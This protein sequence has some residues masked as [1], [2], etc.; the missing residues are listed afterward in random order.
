MKQERIESCDNSCVLNFDGDLEN[1]LENIRSKSSVVNIP[2][3]T[4]N[5]L[6]I[7]IPF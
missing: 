7:N 3:Y 6:N 4:V 2:K 1:R 5:I